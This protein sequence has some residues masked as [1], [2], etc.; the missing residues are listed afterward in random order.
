MNEQ[1]YGR[2][3]NDMLDYN[4]ESPA[5]VAVASAALS[6]AARVIIRNGI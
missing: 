3:V 4:D 5:E 1:E 6:G 2:F